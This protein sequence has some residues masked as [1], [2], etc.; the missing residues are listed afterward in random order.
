MSFFQRFGLR[1]IWLHDWRQ[2]YLPTRFYTHWDRWLQLER[3][4]EEQIQFLGHLG[5]DPQQNSNPF[6]YNAN[7]G[8]YSF[9]FGPLLSKNASG[10]LLG[11]YCWIHAWGINCLN[12]FKN[13][14]K[15]LLKNEAIRRT[16]IRPFLL[17]WTVSKP[18]SCRLKYVRAGWLTKFLMDTSFLPPST[19]IQRYLHPMTKPQLKRQLGVGCL[20]NF[21][22]FIVGGGLLICCIYTWH[23]HF[24]S[25]DPQGATSGEASGFTKYIIEHLLLS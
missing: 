12:T 7:Y 1:L 20:V 14:R 9:I 4:L 6:T 8:C 17:R 2:K 5:W 10:W 23:V 24:I 15:K 19:R 16:K 21:A 22:A 13:R 18:G 25:E 11:N 3:Y